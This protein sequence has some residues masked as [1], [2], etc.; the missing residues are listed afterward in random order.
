MGFCI[1]PDIVEPVKYALGYYTEMQQALEL[2][3]KRKED[4]AA[5]EI[6][7]LG[8]HAKNWFISLPACHR[9]HCCVDLKRVQLYHTM[10]FRI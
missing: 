9:I 8:M 5:R 1:Q 2:E 3:K 6:T 10:F 7:N 4:A